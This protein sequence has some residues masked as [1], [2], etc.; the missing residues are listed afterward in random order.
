[1]AIEIE[2]K[3]LVDHVLWERALSERALWDNA[4]EQPGVEG[5][6]YRQGY[7]CPGTG[8]TVR[9]RIAGE[10]AFVTIK[11]PTHGYSRA[12]YEYPVPLQ[13]AEEM[14]SSLCQQPLIEKI[15][16][17]IGY[18]RHIWEVDVFQGANS[19]LILAE[20]ELPSEDTRFDLPPWLGREV[21][22]DPRYF[23]SAL[24]RTPQPDPIPST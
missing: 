9:V 2:R 14:L 11:G 13:D 8:I 12:E 7:L 6:R 1:M 3:F 4:R 22:G 10:Q 23:N 16:Y 15:R 21:S 20:I 19:G 18:A 5:V 24:A 17:R